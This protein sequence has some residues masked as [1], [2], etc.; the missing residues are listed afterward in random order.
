M[1]LSLGTSILAILWHPLLDT[2]ENNLRFIIAF[3]GNRV[4]VLN[5]SL[6]TAVCS[7]PNHRPYP[8]L[9][10]IYTATCRQSCAGP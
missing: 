7:L 8:L 9:I 10:T 3:G 4:R 5:L 2:L 6:E 1:E